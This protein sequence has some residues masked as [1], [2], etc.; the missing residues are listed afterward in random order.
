GRT[1]DRHRVHSADVAEHLQ[2]FLYLSRVDGPGRYHVRGLPPLPQAAFVGAA[3]GAAP[4]RPRGGA[5]AGGTNAQL[6]A[7][8]A[9]P[10]R[11]G[12]RRGGDTTASPASPRL[13]TGVRAVFRAPW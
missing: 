2:L 4:H 1:R 6:S 12:A 11:G 13:A 3:G 10:A 7:L 8:Q 9:R 5:P